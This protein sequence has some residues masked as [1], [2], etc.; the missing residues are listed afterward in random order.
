MVKLTISNV[1]VR[2]HSELP[3]YASEEFL[4]TEAPEY[5]WIGGTD[6]ND[7]LR[8]VLPYTVI[9][10][11]GFRLIRFQTG[12]LPLEGEI[13]LA[14][15]KS[16]LNGV[17]N[18]FRTA[19]AHMIIPSGNHAIF[20]T[21]PDRA[22]AGSYGTFINDLGQSEE[23]LMSAIRKTFRRYIRRAMA[24]GVQIKC[25]LEFLDAAYQLISET[26]KRTGVKFK[27]YGDFKKRILALGQNVQ[28]FVAEHK[29]VAHGCMVAPF[30]R[31]TAYNCYAG[32]KSQPTL[33]AM[34]LLHWEAIKK[35]RA[36]G[37]RRFDFQGVRTNPEK[38]SKQEG[39]SHY[40]EGFGGE[41]V[42]GYLWKCTL[43]P[44]QSLA[45]SVVVRLLMGGDIVDQERD[46]LTTTVVN[47]SKEISLAP[48]S[49]EPRRV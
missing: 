39:I 37:V 28:V 11:P 6:G 4:K 5:G 14:E 17:V 33:G 2:W 23:V 10:K 19:G 25:G 22:A 35:F 18:Y 41:L 42:Q 32:S 34:H 24:E 29:G 1:D 45:Y 47:Q 31:H 3:I 26:L 16:F 9:R 43:R 40:K 46:K 8:C 21:Y 7:V 20:R 36:M 30:S 38:G 27:K 15:E 13:S 48:G 44:L 12:T 49:P